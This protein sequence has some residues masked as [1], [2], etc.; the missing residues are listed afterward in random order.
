MAKHD[1]GGT[2]K[3]PAIAAVEAAIVEYI[4]DFMERVC[5]GVWEIDGMVF[6]VWYVAITRWCVLSWFGSGW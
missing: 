3:A 6:V 5:C 2:E 4:M 1:C